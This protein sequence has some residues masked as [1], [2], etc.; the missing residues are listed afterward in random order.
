MTGVV[1][2]DLAEGVQISNTCDSSIGHLSGLEIS[3]TDD[4]PSLVMQLGGFSQFIGGNLSPFAGT[5]DQFGNFDGQHTEMVNTD[6][7]IALTLS[8][9]MQARSGPVAG[10]IASLS[11]D[12]GGLGVFC[13]TTWTLTGTRITTVPTD[14]SGVELGRRA[15]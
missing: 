12:F 7:I 15:R 10:F 11:M 4:R 6:L 2:R 13:G 14:W 8:G 5:I 3:F 1:R 9:R